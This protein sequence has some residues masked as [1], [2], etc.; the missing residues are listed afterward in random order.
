MPYAVGGRYVF[1][2][3]E[4]LLRAM[5]QSLSTT[6]QLWDAL[7]EVLKQGVVRLGADDPRLLGNVARLVPAPVLEELVGHGLGQ[8]IRCHGCGSEHPTV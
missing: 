3:D 5:R 4:I 8:A 7:F 6:W 1:K 2:A